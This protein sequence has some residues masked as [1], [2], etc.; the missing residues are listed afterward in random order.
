MRLRVVCDDCGRYE[1]IQWDPESGS[2]AHQVCTCGSEWV[3]VWNLD[4]EHIAK[5]FEPK[6]YPRF[7]RETMVSAAPRLVKFLEDS[8]KADDDGWVQYDSNL[9]YKIL[10]QPPSSSEG[11]LV[12]DFIGDEH[13][14]DNAGLC[15]RR[16]YE[17]PPQTKTTTFTEAMAS[18]Q[19]QQ[20]MMDD[21]I[22]RWA[23]ASRIEAAGPCVV[24]LN[25]DH[26]RALAGVLGQVAYIDPDE[27]PMERPLYKRLYEIR[28]AGR[29]G[30]TERD[31]AWRADVTV[32]YCDGGRHFAGWYQFEMRGEDGV[33]VKEAY[34]P[35]D[36]ANGLPD[37]IG[38]GS[39]YDR[40]R[41]SSGLTSWAFRMFYG[42]EPSGEQRAD[43][44]RERL[45]KLEAGRALTLL[46]GHEGEE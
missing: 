27:R 18:P 46:F 36:F 37:L 30:I 38:L 13:H 28:R 10:K 2:K 31:A 34:L 6:V 4:E 8:E 20:W 39:V 45:A 19:V 32:A 33:I 11:R 5:S 23:L 9:R 41:A 44:I 12:E 17:R 40:A 24:D 1:E 7:N 25:A 29:R 43:Y 3:A 35:E 22:E 21:A 16:G 15:V 42:H 26:L 14:C